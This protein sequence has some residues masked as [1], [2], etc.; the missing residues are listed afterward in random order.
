MKYFIVG[1]IILVWIMLSRIMWLLAKN[2][3]APIIEL[4][5]EVFGG[6]CDGEIHVAKLGLG[7][8][9]SLSDN[10]GTC[11]VF[12]RGNVLDNSVKVSVRAT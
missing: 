11:M 8:G 6:P 1:F 5:I 12:R 2:K 7:D 4:N 9:Y 10:T 3:T